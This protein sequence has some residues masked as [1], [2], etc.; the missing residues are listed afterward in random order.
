MVICKTAPA[1]RLLAQIFFTFAAGFLILLLEERMGRPAEA[2][3]LIPAV[4][5]GF[6]S[7]LI[8]IA[9]A[10][11]DAGIKKGALLNAIAS[12]EVFL[13]ALHVKDGS[14]MRILPVLL[15]A[16]TAMLSAFCLIL[17]MK[18]HER[19]RRRVMR[20]K[21]SEI[22]RSV[23]FFL[24]TFAPVVLLLVC[25]NSYAA[26]KD[27][28]EDAA[29]NGRADYEPKY[30]YGEECRLEQNLNRIRPFAAGDEWN[31]IPLDKKQDALR[32]VI[33]NDLRYQGVPQ[34]VGIRFTDMADRS[35]CGYYDPV[36]K[37][38]VMNNY[39]L[40]RDGSLKNLENALHESRH[41][42][43]ISMCNLYIC[44]P[45]E[46]K[47]L[48]CFGETKEW[49]LSFDSYAESRKVYEKYRSSLVEEDARLYAERQ[50]RIYLMEICRLV[51]A[52]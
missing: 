49:C 26:L 28:E 29:G 16:G 39:Y 36:E 51:S 6:V 30:V 37:E 34:K 11:K 15:A 18:P 32:A 45:D 1:D 47:A 35:V 23:R 33:E 25:L 9:G 24:V 21:W 52:Q 50:G 42:Y 7:C 17:L 5:C 3:R 20:H 14:F 41:A 31:G 8:G 4:I 43:Q 48:Q 46:Q 40:I 38:I 13:I 2:E 22:F 27:A 19:I 10:V 44:L 12:A